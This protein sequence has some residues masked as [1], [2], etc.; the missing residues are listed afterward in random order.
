VAVSS[1]VPGILVL[2][3]ISLLAGASVLVE[4]RR[5]LSSGQ[6]EQLSSPFERDY[7]IRIKRL[8]FGVA[9]LSL[10]LS[11]IP[12]IFD[13]FIV[14][15]I[16]AQVFLAMGLMGLERF[17]FPNDW[18]RF[19][20]PRFDAGLQFE[21]QTIAGKLGVKLRKVRVMPEEEP[22]ANFVYGVLEVSSGLRALPEEERRFILAYVL[23]EGTPGSGPH[24]LWIIAGAFFLLLGMVLVHFFLP[25]V[26]LVPFGLLLGLVSLVKGRKLREGREAIALTTATE[27]VKSPT[28]VANCLDRLAK[29]GHPTAADKAR[30]LRQLPT[31]DGA[32]EAS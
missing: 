8:R 2:G 28:A 22:S 31:A 20:A 3:A 14:G 32:A 15:P 7:R 26:T 4:R 18:R 19:D 27:L 17:V 24:N 5:A 21:A 13:E 25:A 9:I 10:V 11:V 16:I 29:R 12:L 1:W 30:R 23:A 6:P